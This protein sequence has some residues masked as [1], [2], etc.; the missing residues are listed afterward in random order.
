M[1]GVVV[2]VVRPA[3]ASVRAGAAVL[4]LESMKM[5]HEVAAESDGVVREV[6]VAAGDQVEDG[7]LLFSLDAG[8]GEDGAEAEPAAVAEAQAV[9]VAVPVGNTMT[10]HDKPRLLA[11]VRMLGLYGLVSEPR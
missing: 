2:E 9:F 5:H 11:A 3:G 4:V 8:T 7:Q 1:T 6:A 10:S